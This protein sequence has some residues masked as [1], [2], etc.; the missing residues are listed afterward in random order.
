MSGFLYI[1]V[2]VWMGRSSIETSDISM[3]GLLH[4]CPIRRAKV[5]SLC[6]KNEGD[7]VKGL[8]IMSILHIPNCLLNGAIKLN[9]VWFSG[10]SAWKLHSCDQKVQIEC[11]TAYYRTLSLAACAGTWATPLPISKIAEFQLG[12]E[13]ECSD[14]IATWEKADSNK[15]R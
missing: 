6:C 10:T 11:G 12:K 3:L 1:C 15:K 7:R 8:C 5:Q 2:H 14:A 9:H 4:L 13:P